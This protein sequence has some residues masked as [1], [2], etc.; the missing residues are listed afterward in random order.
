MYKMLFIRASSGQI[1]TCNRTPLMRKCFHNLRT[2]VCQFFA[3]KNCLNAVLSA[4]FATVELSGFSVFAS[5]FFH[6]ILLFWNQVLTCASFNPR[7]CDSLARF[8]ESRYFCSE[9][10]F[11]KTLSCKSVNTVR[12]FRH[13]FPLGV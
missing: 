13:R 7:T 9:N 5:L 3:P 1:L 10:V 12:N 4:F 8:V 2:L 6:F 11:S